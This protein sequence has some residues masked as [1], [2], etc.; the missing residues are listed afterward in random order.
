VN[1]WEKDNPIKWNPKASRKELAI[2]LFDKADLKPKLVK[3]QC[4]SL[5]ID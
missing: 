1:R 5:H 4:R 2:L 3:R